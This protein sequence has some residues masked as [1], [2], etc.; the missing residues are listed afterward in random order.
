[1]T[2]IFFKLLKKV[3]RHLL[4]KKSKLKKKNIFLSKNFEQNENSNFAQVIGLKNFLC[5]FSCLEKNH[6]F[7]LF[8]LF[9][10]R[11]WKKIIFFSFLFFFVYGKKYFFFSS[12]LEKNHFFGHFFKFFFFSCMGKI[13]FFFVFGKKSFFWFFFV[14]WRENFIYKFQYWKEFQFLWIKK[15]SKLLF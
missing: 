12:C 4:W 2:L 7:S 15:N 14:L 1:M 10:L 8:F 3:L 5:F 11:V 9:F 6:Y 13:C